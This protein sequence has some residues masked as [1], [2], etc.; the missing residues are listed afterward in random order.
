[1]KKLLIGTIVAL[2]ICGQANA[3]YTFIG[4]WDVNA[5]PEWGTAPLQYTGQETAALL[6]GGSASDYVI[7]TK[8]SDSSL[9][10]F[11]AWVS[12][13]GM[14]HSGD[15]A[16]QDFVVDL[17]G[18]GMYDTPGETSAYVRDWCFDGNCVNYAFKIS[19]NVPE[20]G[21]LALAALGL[22]GLGLMRRN[23]RKAKQY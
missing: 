19:N 23:R 14:G 22:S 13:W 6:F 7:S 4:S 8:G 15:V 18:N 17:D 11:S 9:I 12:G 3:G 10:D 5:G 20:P 1:M 2:A 21:T 16:A